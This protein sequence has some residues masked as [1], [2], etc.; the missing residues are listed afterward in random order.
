MADLIVRWHKDATKSHWY[1]LSE[2]DLGS[3]AGSGVYLIWHTGVNPRVIYVGRG[4][5]ADRLSEHQRDASILS[6]ESQGTLLT[7]WA[8]VDDR[9]AKGVER[10]LIDTYLPLVNRKRPDATPISVNLLIR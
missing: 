3:I 4:R 9:F 1:K 8:L 5:V 7:T 10:Y 6:Y 2:I